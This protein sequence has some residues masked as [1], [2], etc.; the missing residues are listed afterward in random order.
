[1]HD[2]VLATKNKGK[3]AEMRA[4]LAGIPVHV[5]SLSDYP[6]IPDIPETGSTFAENAV[7]KAEAAARYTGKMVLAD[8]SGLEVDA[9]GGDPGI[10]SNRFA[11]PGAT[12]LDKCMRILE[13][14]HD[15][16][17]EK[18]T[19]RF[20]AVIAIC[21]P[22]GETQVVEGVCEG[23]IAHEPHGANGFGY[24]PIFYIPRLDKTMAELSADQ[25]NAISHRG[26]ALR[27]ARRILLEIL[28]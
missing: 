25:K 16:P 17:D 9:L 4:L 13:L 18:R 1:M 28:R 23:R 21:T 22:M 6:E 19:A 15:V 26:Q 3:I 11:G 12:D 7:L 8:D 20:R 2:L 24:D 10:F 5:S 27:E 14:L